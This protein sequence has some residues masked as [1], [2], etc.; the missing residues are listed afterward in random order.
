MI[1]MIAAVGLGLV[2]AASAYYYYVHS[3]RI[4]ISDGLG[5]SLG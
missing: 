2:S 4:V 1:F 3:K 5:P